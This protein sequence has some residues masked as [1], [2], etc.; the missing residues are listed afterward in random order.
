MMEQKVVAT[1]VIAD[2][3][4]DDV[5]GEEDR[6]WSVEKPLFLSTDMMADR[7]EILVGMAQEDAERA[8]DQFVSRQLHLENVDENAKDSWPPQDRGGYY[9]H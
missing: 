8:A 2:T 3:S 9:Y 5:L 7:E 1:V 6:T 4:L